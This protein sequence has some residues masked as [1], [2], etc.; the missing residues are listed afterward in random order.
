MTPKA[1]CAPCACIHSIHPKGDELLRHRVAIMVAPRA[2]LALWDRAK[3]EAKAHQKWFATGLVAIP[4][5][6]REAMARRLFAE[7]GE[8]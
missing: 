2:S 7:L 6:E 8:T 3:A 5:S 1:Y 4:D